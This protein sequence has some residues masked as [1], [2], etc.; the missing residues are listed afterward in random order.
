MKDHASVISLEKS[1]P[2]QKNKNMKERDN[3]SQ[4]VT[5]VYCSTGHS[6]IVL[7]GLFIKKL[8]MQRQVFHNELNSTLILFSRISFI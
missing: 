5:D 6:F 3:T 4:Q 8:T 1:S 2:L 7:F